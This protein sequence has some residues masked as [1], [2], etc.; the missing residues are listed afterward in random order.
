MGYFWLVRPFLTD[1][2]FDTTLG[3]AEGKR[4]LLFTADTP[5]SGAFLKDLDKYPY[6]CMISSHVLL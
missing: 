3:G 6:L 4:K 5:K 2:C 1:V